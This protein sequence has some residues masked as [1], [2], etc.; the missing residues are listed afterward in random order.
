MFAKSGPGRLNINGADLEL[1]DL[2]R[3]VKFRVGQLV[4][5]GIGKVE[6]DEYGSVHC[7]VRHLELGFDPAAPGADIDHLSVS[8][9]ELAGIPAGDFN[10]T[11]G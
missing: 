11:L 4:G 10:K 9:A 7:L 1:G 2:G 5:C 8:D 6:G 3:G